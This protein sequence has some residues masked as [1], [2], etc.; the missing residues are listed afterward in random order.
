MARFERLFRDGNFASHVTRYNDYYPRQEQST[1]IV[2]TINVA[3]LL[4]LPA[5]VDTGAPWCILDPET[6]SLIETGIEGTYVPSGRLLIRGV[7]YEGRLVRIPIGIMTT[8]GDS[9]EVD[10]TV[11]VPTL[12]SG[13][14]WSHPN[15]IGL[16][17]LLS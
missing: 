2:L 5:I 17:G 9:S 1:R 3:G 8:Q 13:D 15:F 6:L 14:T 12:A 7:L 16:E 11:F 10:A 4:T